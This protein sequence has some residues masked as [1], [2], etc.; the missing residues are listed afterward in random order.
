MLVRASFIKDVADSP[1][2]AAHPHLA[3]AA[4]TLFEAMR[5]SIAAAIGSERV[6]DVYIHG[7]ATMREMDVMVN[8]IGLSR[9]RRWS[10]YAAQHLHSRDEN[11]RGEEAFPDGHIS[12]ELAAYIDTGSRNEV[13][14]KYGPVSFWRT[15]HVTDMSGLLEGS[16]LSADLYW[17]T[18]MVTTMNRTF[19]NSEFKGN[20]GHWDTSGVTEMRE[21][22][23]QS[24]TTAESVSSWCVSRVLD[25]RGVFTTGLPS[26]WRL[27]VG[28]GT[29]AASRLIDVQHEH[30][31]RAAKYV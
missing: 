30:G 26:T 7:D 16:R 19:A 20:I 22:F 8:S 4:T 6:G 1:V 5:P 9:S 27:P 21:T 13:L 18:S 23:A 11:E 29:T 17:D 14:I 31:S 24:A 10:G 12:H 2:Y 15:S 3:D 25:A 28:R